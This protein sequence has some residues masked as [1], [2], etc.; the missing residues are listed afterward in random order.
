MASYD[1]VF[2][3]ADAIDRAETTDP[4]AVVAALETTD[5]TL[6]QG[7]YYFEYTSS[8]PLP[9]DDSVPDYLWHQ[10]PDPAVIVIQYTEEGQDPGDA[11]V[12]WPPAYQTDEGVNYNPPE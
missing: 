12:V 6:T 1:S 2:V 5:I 4:E 10:W 11:P 9:D 7:R 8:N 3:L